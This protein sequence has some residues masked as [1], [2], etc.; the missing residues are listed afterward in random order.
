M[1]TAHET[2]WKGIEYD[3]CRGVRALDQTSESFCCSLHYADEQETL[4]VFYKSEFV[5]NVV[6]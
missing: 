1:K 5:Q 3:K 4:S 6:S 2:T